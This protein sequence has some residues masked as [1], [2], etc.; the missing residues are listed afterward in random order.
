MD[1]ANKPGSRARPAGV[2]IHGL[3]PRPAGPDQ[4]PNPGSSRAEDRARIR[5]N[6]GSGPP[7]LVDPH[8]SDLEQ[9][10]AEAPGSL[11][12][13]RAA[14]HPSHSPPAAR[15]RCARRSR[16]LRGDEA[17]AGGAIGGADDEPEG[18]ALVV[19]GSGPLSSCC[20]S[21]PGPPGWFGTAGRRPRRRRNSAAVNSPGEWARRSPR[22]GPPGA[23]AGTAGS[24]GRARCRRMGGTE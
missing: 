10:T 22:Y 5:V 17:A 3:A 2:G 11:D 23:T 20:W 14:A 1:A 19:R 24:G 4:C 18:Q 12:A 8:P 9:A 6:G 21:S 13:E 15:P 16:C 7:F